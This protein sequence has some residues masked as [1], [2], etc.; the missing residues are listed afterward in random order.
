MAS[1]P[2]PTDDPVAVQALG[3]NV[4]QGRH[5]EG[6]DV[7]S[8]AVPIVR[9]GRTIGALEVEQSLDAVHS[10]VR[11][12]VLALIGIGVLALVLGL[13]VAWILAGSIAQAAALARRGRTPTRRRR[14]R[15]PRTRARLERAGRGGP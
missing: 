13:G 7:L 14:L 10:Q 9:N 5:H 6:R 12:D 2:Q 11:Q 1:P 15:G 8:T 3:G 4:A